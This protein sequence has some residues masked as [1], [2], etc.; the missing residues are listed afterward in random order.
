MGHPAFEIP[1]SR[2]GGET[3]G[4]PIDFSIRLSLALL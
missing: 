1:A 2:K 3:W 4:I